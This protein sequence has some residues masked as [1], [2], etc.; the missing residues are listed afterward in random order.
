MRE[1]FSVKPVD[2]QKLPHIKIGNRAYVAL[3]C[4]E[5]PYNECLIY[6]DSVDSTEAEIE[7]I[8]REQFKKSMK[9]RRDNQA[10]KKV[11][12]KAID[13]S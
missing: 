4:F 6:D 3:E 8:V 9:N 10:K 7:R 2:K 1:N 12:E 13:I 11:D 5:P